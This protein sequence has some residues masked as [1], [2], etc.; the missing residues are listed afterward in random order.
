MINKSAS[1]YAVVRFCY[2]SYDNRTNWAPLIPIT[3]TYFLKKYP[4]DVKTRL[5]RENRAESAR[6]KV[7]GGHSVFL[8]LNLEPDLEPARISEVFTSRKDLSTQ[9]VTSVHSS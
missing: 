7:R 4:Y 3:I 5:A 2:H 1:R 8:S 6:E 9:T